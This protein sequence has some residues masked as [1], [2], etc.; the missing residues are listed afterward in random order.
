MHLPDLQVLLTTVRRLDSLLTDEYEALKSQ[1]IEAFEAL[2]QEKMSLL[3]TL[4][5]SGIIEDPAQATDPEQL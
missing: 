2:K 4:A 5:S 3:H 1:K